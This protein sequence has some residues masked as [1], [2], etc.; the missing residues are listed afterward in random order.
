MKLLGAV[1]VLA[2]AALQGQADAG[3]V[4]RVDFSN[5]GLTPSKWT[6][7]MHPDGTAHFHSEPGEK[8]A[9][10]LHAI[11]PG[12]VDR[13]IR[14]SDDFVQR[15][16]ETVRHHKFLSL[17]CES[18][19]KVA[20]QG[21]KKLTYTGPDGNGSCEFNYSKNKDIQ[22]LGESF[23]A[24]ASTVV[25]GARLELLLQ[26]DPLGLDQEMEFMKD[27]SEDGRLQQMC[28]I[29]P[30]LTKLVD[31]PGVMERVRRRARLLL[32]ESAK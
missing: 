4:L 11:E 25:E 10:E 7:E 16:F 22:S 1:L 18:H 8:T 6:L 21:W 30:I 26:H 12:P 24:V 13:D 23:V 5:P 14:L 27:A 31:D 19:L 2:G 28:A 9:R 3:P 17:D 29:Q 32:E 15:A 20:F